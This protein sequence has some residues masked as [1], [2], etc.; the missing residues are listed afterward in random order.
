M[1][2]VRQDY[3]QS[4]KVVKLEFNAPLAFWSPWKHKNMQSEK[5]HAYKKAECKKA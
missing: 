2:D 4:L 3:A 1:K 5:I